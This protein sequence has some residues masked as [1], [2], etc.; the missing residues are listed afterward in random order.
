M[1]L[2]K[3]QI[4]NWE[5]RTLPDIGHYPMCEDPELITTIIEEFVRR[6]QLKAKPLS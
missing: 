5:T 1:E 3:E 6:H 4:P 2:T